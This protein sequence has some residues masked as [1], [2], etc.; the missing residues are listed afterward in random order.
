MQCLQRMQGSSVLQG[1]E[2]VL[3]RGLQDQASTVD[4]LDPLVLRELPAGDSLRLPCDCPTSRRQ[5]MRHPMMVIA[6]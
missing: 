5:L 2:G 4:D 1:R 3:V 6:H